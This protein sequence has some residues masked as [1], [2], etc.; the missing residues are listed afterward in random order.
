MS[1]KKVDISRRYGFIETRLYWGGGLTADEL[2]QAFGVSRQ[3]AQTTI[4]NYKTAYPENIWT[5]RQARQ[6]APGLGFEAAY[7]RTGS[8]VFLD[9]LRGQSLVGHYA[10]DRDWSELPCCDVGQYTRPKL[11]DTS[12]RALILALYRCQTVDVYYQSKKQ[13]QHWLVSPNHLVFADNR[14]HIRAYVHDLKTYIDLVLTRFLQVEPGPVD[15]WVSDYGD[16]AWH[17]S[18]ILHFAP[19]PDLPA[20]TRAAL[21]LDFGLDGRRPYQVRCTQALSY[22]VKRHMGRLHPESGLPF[23]REVAPA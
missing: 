17:E 13:R 1:V 10:E 9:Y 16:T 15:T 23:W 19:N 11:V 14:Y 20:E 21:A 4:N 3:A 6:Q 8:S 2:A 22:Y 18:E 12:V 5:D 7:I